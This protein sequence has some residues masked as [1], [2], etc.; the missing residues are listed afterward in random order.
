MFKLPEC[1]ECAKKVII[2]ILVL[3]AIVFAS[4]SYSSITGVPSHVYVHE[5]GECHIDEECDVGKICFHECTAYNSDSCTSIEEI[6]KC[7]NYC[8]TDSDCINATCQQK[9]M[10]SFSSSKQVQICIP[11]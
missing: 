2:V 1:P 3:F 7:L 9:T 6:G 11:N 8:S 5:P 10:W 4:F